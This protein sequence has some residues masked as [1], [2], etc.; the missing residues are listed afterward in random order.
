MECPSCSSPIST[1]VEHNIQVESCAQCGGRWFD[2]NGIH[3]Y[4]QS[5]IAN[6][7]V[8]PPAIDLYRKARIT[9]PKNENVRTCP[10]CQSLLMK[11]NYAYDSNI[12]VD[13]CVDCRGLWIDGNEIIPLAQYLKGHPALRSMGVSMAQYAKEQAAMNEPMDE[14]ADTFS[15]PMLLLFGRFGIILPLKDETSRFKTPVVMWTILAS[16]VL[17]YTLQLTVL[18]KDQVA[19]L[20]LTP[21][22]VFA[23]VSWVSLVTACFLHADLFHLGANALFLWIFGDDIEQRLGHVSFLLFYLVAGVAGNALQAVA[24]PASVI[25]VLGASGAIAGLIGAYLVLHPNAR[26][27]TL[28]FYRL[29]RIPAW[30]YIVFWLV[31]QL[32]YGGIF[33]AAGHPSGVAWFAHIGGFAVGVATAIG[34]KCTTEKPQCAS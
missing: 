21:S 30:W 7:A 20:A 12:F 26:L 31:I 13:K 34:V 14:L 27:T 9:P 32:I 17:V 11:M 10:K 5:I 8:Q 2:E 18:S 1:I 19:G 22:K 16:M 3:A 23:G 28:V 6:E 33:Y 29:V 24:Y 15:S 25:P 4:F